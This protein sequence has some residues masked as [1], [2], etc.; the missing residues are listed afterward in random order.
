MLDLIFALVFS[1]IALLCLTFAGIAL[2]HGDPFFEYFA[3][4]LLFSILA[5]QKA[6][7]AKP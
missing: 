1:V 5:N 3:I 2:L 7:N 4:G 6:H